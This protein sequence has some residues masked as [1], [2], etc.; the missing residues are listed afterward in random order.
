MRYVQLLSCYSW[1]ARCLCNSL[2]AS[3]H[4]LSGDSSS[5]LA[6]FSTSP[7]HGG[8]G[9][10]VEDPMF[11]VTVMGSGISLRHKLGQWE[12]SL[13]FSWELPGN[14][15]H[16]FLISRTRKAQDSLLGCHTVW[17]WSWHRRKQT[18]SSMW[19]TR[20]SWLLKPMRAK[21]TPS[22]VNPSSWNNISF[23]TKLAWSVSLLPTKDS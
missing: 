4:S 21:G 6:Q 9:Y 14:D 5:I 10:Q 23:E 1:L 3:H 17:E 8:R 11:L 18:Q 2:W 22:L 15:H 19:K 13:L 16:L 12:S 7:H 20:V